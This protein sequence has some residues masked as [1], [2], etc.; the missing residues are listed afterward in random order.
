MEKYEFSFYP[1]MNYVGSS[2]YDEEMSETF[3]SMKFV[4]YT[5]WN[6]YRDVSILEHL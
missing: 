2:L 5:H 3:T 4:K 1:N 6:Q